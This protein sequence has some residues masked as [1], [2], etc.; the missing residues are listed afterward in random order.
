MGEIG[1]IAGL[2]DLASRSYFTEPRGRWV[3]RGLSYIEYSLVPTVGRNPPAPSSRSGFERSVFNTFQRKAYGLLPTLPVNDWEL[4]ALARHHGLLTRLLDWTHN[5]LVA[6]YF[7]VADN[8]GMD[9]QVFALAARAAAKED[10]ERM[11]PFGISQPVKYYPKTVTPRIRAQEGLFV[12]CADLE[13][14]LEHALPAD[15]HIER[16]TIPA[17]RKEHLRYELYRIGVHESSL[18]PGLD[19]LAAR[20]RW[21][22]AVSPPF[23]PKTE[24]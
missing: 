9:G 24:R 16:L 14:P 12:A 11:A 18:F 13:V 2:L 7:A 21:Q 5:L 20:I 15:W 22:H 1:S 3:F 23:T 10:I 6:V 4:L 17:A 8:T 19:G